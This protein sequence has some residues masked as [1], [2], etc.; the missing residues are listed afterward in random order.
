MK[1][2]KLLVDRYQAKELT[3]Q[4]YSARCNPI[5]VEA[6]DG[7][8]TRQWPVVVSVVVAISLLLGLAII[9]ICY[10]KRESF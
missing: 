7:I 10:W 9:A 4:R 6:S 5:S 8:A 1:L 2:T 3:D